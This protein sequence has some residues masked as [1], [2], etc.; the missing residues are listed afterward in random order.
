MQVEFVERGPMALAGMSYYG[1]LTGEGWSRENPIGQLWER[2]NQFFDST[3]AF[4]ESRAVKPGIGYEINIWNEKEYQESKCFTV[5]VG[6]EVNRHDEMPLQLVG[7]VL[8]A[9]IYAHLTPRGK[10]ITTWE[11][12]FYD[13]WLPGSGYQLQAFNDYQ[14]QIQAYEEG[15]F[16]GLGDLLEQSEIDVYVPVEKVDQ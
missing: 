8:P 2:F 10:G 13:E 7:K 5:F 3:P 16:H 9:G 4:S 14:F 15:R 11:H 6:V 12:T 1:P